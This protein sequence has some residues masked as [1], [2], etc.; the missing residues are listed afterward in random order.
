MNMESKS[1]KNYYNYTSY[2]N[3]SDEEQKGYVY[4]DDVGLNDH[5][6]AS[7]HEAEIEEY[8][9]FNEDLEI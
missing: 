9:A 2:D 3:D 4:K 7:E 8:K 6:D 5:H 1:T